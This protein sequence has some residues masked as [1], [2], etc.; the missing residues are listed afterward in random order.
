MTVTAISLTDPSSGYSVP[1]MP[2]DGCAAQTLD[3]NAPARAVT[4][5]LVNTHGSY[6]VTRYKSAAAVSLSMILFP[7]VTQTPELFMDT[8]GPLLDPGLRPTLI[9]TND[10]WLTPRQL[11]VRYDSTAKPFSD[12]TNWPVQI[13]WQAPNAVWESSVVTTADLPTIIPSDTGLEFDPTVGVSSTTIGFTFPAS[14]EPSPSQVT[15]IGTTTSQW[16]AFLYGP[17]TGPRLANDS[18]GDSLNFTTDMPPLNAGDYIFV[19]SLTRTAYLNSDT[20]VP[21]TQYIDFDSSSWWLI[22]PGLNIIRFYPA[23][24]SSG[25]QCVLNFRPAWPA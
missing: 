12:P 15:S 17:C 5:D 25:S 24:A 21:M 14:T 23:S 13:S 10:Q 7:G 22:Q 18:T 20:S 3:V 4:E 6:D 2:A 19:D 11:T 9:V 16:Q 8:L 1:L